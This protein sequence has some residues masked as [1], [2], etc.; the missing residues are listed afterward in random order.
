MKRLLALIVLLGAL[1]GL[2]NHS[3]FDFFACDGLQKVCFVTKE[4][5]LDSEDVIKSGNQFYCNLSIEQ[6]SQTYKSIEELDGMILYFFDTSL[7]QITKYYKVDYFKGQVVEG[8]EVFYGYSPLYKDFK[9]VDNKKIN[10][11]IVINA[12]EIILGFPAI[13]VGF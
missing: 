11:Q 4:N 7:E 5:L 10:A 12:N 13:L 2:Q 3:N 1:L 8:K 9:L 6:A